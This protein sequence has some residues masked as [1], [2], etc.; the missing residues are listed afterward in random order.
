MN[1]I[2]S[3]STYITEVENTEKHS[4]SAEDSEVPRSIPN[5]SHNQNDW[6]IGDELLD[7]EISEEED[8]S[9]DDD[10]VKLCSFTQTQ[11]EFMNQHWYVHSYLIK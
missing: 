3:A 5:Q 7:D 6:S 1:D 2:V 11:K 4:G 9:E 10:L 8:E